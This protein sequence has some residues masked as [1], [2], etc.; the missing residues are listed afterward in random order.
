[1]KWKVEKIDF[2]NVTKVG[3]KETKSEF[4]KFLKAFNDFKGHE[5]RHWVLSLLI[6]E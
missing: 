5:Q 3:S 4:Y 6:F 2:E 1:M